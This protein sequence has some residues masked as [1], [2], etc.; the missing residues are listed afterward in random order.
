MT[1]STLLGELQLGQ[2]L[3]R[4]YTPIYGA[5]IPQIETF[6]KSKERFSRCYFK[7]HLTGELGTERTGSCAPPHEDTPLQHLQ[8]ADAPQ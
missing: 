1:R 8:S 6:V 5:I 4:C 2:G 7:R 3:R